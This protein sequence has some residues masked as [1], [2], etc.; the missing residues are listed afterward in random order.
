[1]P[2]LG[3]VTLLVALLA[4]VFIYMKVRDEVSAFWLS[5]AIGATAQFVS[6]IYTEA[7]APDGD[8]DFIFL[9]ACII[10]AM[11]LVACYAACFA[12]VHGVRRLLSGNDQTAAGAT[13][14]L[15][16]GNRIE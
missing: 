7:S 15:P 12:F 10:R 8:L 1:M 5:A 4:P 3:I 9:L 14:P 6:M 13:A 2:D 16:P 11:I